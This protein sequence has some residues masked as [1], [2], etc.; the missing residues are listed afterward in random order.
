MDYPRNLE[1]VIADKLL[2]PEAIFIF[3]PRQSGKTTL[4]KQLM[5]R[6]GLENALYIDLE[7]PALQHTF[8]QGIEEVIKYISYNR[9]KPQGRLY[10]FLD[11]VQYL[12]DFSRIVKL[13]VDHH[14]EDFKLIMS[15]SSSALIKYHFKDSLVGRKLVYELLP[16][17]FEEFLLFKSEDKL[18][19]AIIEAPESIPDNRRQDLERYLEEFIVFGSYP[20]VV[21][22]NTFREKWDILKDIVSS[23]ILKD[24]KDLFKIEKTHQLNHMIRFL[25]LNIGKELNIH[26][27]SNEVSLHRETA[28]SYLDILEECYIIRRLKPFHQNLGTELRRMNKLYFVDSGVRNILIDNLNDLD[29]RSDRGELL[30]N[31][32]YGH[33]LHRLEPGQKIRFWQ[34]R[35]K[36]EIDFVIDSPKQLIAIETKYSGGKATSFSVF[37]NAYPNARCYVACL[38]NATNK[39][40]IPVWQSASLLS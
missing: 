32:V 7:Y 16:L 1:Q 36:Q 14:S 23:Y 20:K 38:K 34:T 31:M 4:M 18:A 19:K 12:S 25:S 30:E 13:M 15:G 37:R 33:L 5:Q 8:S 26:N 21:K 3:G 29:S 2:Q 6:V 22:V 17:C 9:I 28:R 39:D 27:L 10:V 40:E 24:I 11:E 35:N